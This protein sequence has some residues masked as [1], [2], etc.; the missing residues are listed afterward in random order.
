[1]AKQAGGGARGG[2]DLEAGLPRRP[3]SRGPSGRGAAARRVARGTV[4]AAAWEDSDSGA[5]GPPFP[6]RG[7]AAGGGGGG[8]DGG[9]GGGEREGPRTG[10]GID[11]AWHT[12]ADVSGRLVYI[13][14]AAATVVAGQRGRWWWRW[15]YANDGGERRFAS[16][17]INVPQA[18]H[19]PGWTAA[20]ARATVK[21]R[22]GATG[23]AAVW[24]AR[25]NG[26][27]C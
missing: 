14:V 1:M 19:G 26:R 17:R 6:T 8:G 20:G 2:R 18:A 24:P 7:R 27:C 5:L 11:L 10:V 15:R 4:G 3:P 25:G 22:A 13:A 12:G 16:P 9:G 21:A 23:V